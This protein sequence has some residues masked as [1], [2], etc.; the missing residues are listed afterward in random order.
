MCA[1]AL[2]PRTDTAPRYCSGA[3]RQLTQC[4]PSPIADDPRKL[5]TLSAPFKVRDLTLFASTETWRLHGFWL[6]YAVSLALVLTYTDED[7]KY[8]KVALGLFDGAMLEF[9]VLSAFVLAGFILLVIS[10]WRERRCHY[11]NLC[12]TCKALLL[13]LAVVSHSETPRDRRS[14]P[15]SSS[16][17]ASATVL[18]ASPGWQVIHGTGS[19]P[20]RQIVRRNNSDLLGLWIAGH[21][22]QTWISS[23][24]GV[25]W[26][27]LSSVRHV[28]SLTLP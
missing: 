9:R 25:T 22:L 10:A 24:E 3:E 17:A 13:C 20:L 1:A 21:E 14:S 16:K 2:R 19:G 18:P 12:A 27:Q 6:L 11:T 5:K 28:H 15:L 4:A 7:Q 8:S 23:N 26:S